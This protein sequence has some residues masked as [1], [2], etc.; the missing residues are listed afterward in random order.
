MRVGVLCLQMKIDLSAVAPW[1]P[2]SR[3]TP[4]N[5]V[6]F[7]LKE[8]YAKFGAFLRFVT[9]FVTFDDN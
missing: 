8:M 9:I 5:F 4:S 2:G 7:A 3:G 6:L 1:I